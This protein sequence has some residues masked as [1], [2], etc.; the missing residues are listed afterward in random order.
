MCGLR[1]GEAE[2]LTVND[3]SFSSST[4]NVNKTYDR[5]N[6]IV[7]TPKTKNSVRTVYMIDE[8]KNVLHELID[9]HKKCEG[10]DG[11]ALIFGFNTYISEST[12]KRVQE[13]ACVQSDVKTIRTDDLRQSH[14]SLLIDMGLTPHL[15]AERL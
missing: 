10:F 4:I 14:V 11:D 8:L 1:K 13:R 3:I 9:I 2:A 5:T 12:L 7:T 15:I 6:H